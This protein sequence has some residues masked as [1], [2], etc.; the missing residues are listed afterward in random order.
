MFISSKKNERC[1]YAETILKVAAPETRIAA[2]QHSIEKRLQKVSLLYKPLLAHFSSAYLPN[3]A[4]S[5][6]SQF[7]VAS[8]KEQQTQGIIKE[9]KPG[10]LTGH[11]VNAQGRCVYFATELLPDKASAYWSNH[12]KWL[13]L[14][15]KLLLHLIGECRGLTSLSADKAEILRRVEQLQERY[16][17]YKQMH[18]AP[19]VLAS[20]VKLASQSPQSLDKLHMKLLESKSALEGFHIE[21]TSKS[22]Q[23][24]VCYVST[25]P[26]QDYQFKSFEKKHFTNFDDYLK[27]NKNIVL[28]VGN[29][30]YHGVSEHRGLTKSPFA[31]LQGI[32]SSF[33]YNKENVPLSMALHFF[34]MA[35]R[36]KSAD[37]M[38]VSPMM[39]MRSI[40]DRTLERT[41]LRHLF[42]R[43]DQE[44]NEKGWSAYTI[45]VAPGEIPFVAKLSQ[46]KVPLWHE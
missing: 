36:Q 12:I 9:I 38:T 35:A 14:H 2:I 4:S 44:L 24:H 15:N 34:I 1:K 28:T 25:V 20:L 42:A 32:S 7:P 21:N 39:S 3:T 16:P 17:L 10:L 23:R 31:L 30:V 5:Y 13:Q 26:I 37:Y 46:L 45:T 6:E 43:G 40:L 27:S 22:L 8:H 19:K 18:Y 29:R 33:E 11:L 41:G